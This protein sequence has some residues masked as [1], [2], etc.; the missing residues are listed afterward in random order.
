MIKAVFFDLDGTLLDRDASVKSFID[1]QYDRLKKWVGDIP[2]EVFISRFIKLDDR[3][4]VWKDRVY[5]QLVKEFKIEGLSW[6]TFLQDYENCFKQSCVPFENLKSMLSGLKHNSY[7]LGMI[8][9]GKGRFQMDNIEALGIKQ[10]FDVILISEWEGVKK[11]DPL[12]FKRAMK[13]LNVLPHESVYIG[14]HPKND[15]EASKQ[16]GMTG[17]WKRDSFVGN[18]ETELII[19]ELSEIPGLIKNINIKIFS[20]L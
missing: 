15:V 10:Y 12:I 18:F 8:T 2:K 1:D 6:D 17:I 11:P 19:D 16:V 14:D 7:S 13:N 20:H 3:G 5:Q 9:N 4:Y